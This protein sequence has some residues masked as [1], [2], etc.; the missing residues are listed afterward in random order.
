MTGLEYI[1]ELYKSTT[2][3][4]CTH[5]LI[6]KPGE[7]EQIQWFKSYP[8]PYP[9]LFSL[10]VD[11]MGLEMST[12][13]GEFDAGIAVEI[14]SGPPEENPMTIL[15]PSD[16]KSSRAPILNASAFQMRW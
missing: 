1:A 6:V 15:T 13:A 12:D 11:T 8:M 5:L 10:G 3:E 9:C 7:E 4:D 2:H 16:S 14:V